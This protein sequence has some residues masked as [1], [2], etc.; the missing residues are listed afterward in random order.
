MH[1]DLPRRY[2]GDIAAFDRSQDRDRFRHDGCYVLHGVVAQNLL[3]PDRR[4]GIAGKAG[5]IFGPKR[6]AFLAGRELQSFIGCEIALPFLVVTFEAGLAIDGL[7]GADET[8]A[9]VSEHGPVVRVP[10]PQHRA[11]D[12]A[13][14]SADRGARPDPARRRIADPR[15]AVVLVNVFDFYS[16]DLVRQVVVL[17]TGNRVRQRVEAK[18]LQSRQEA[19]ELL[20]AKSAE[21]HLGGLPRAGA[22]HESEN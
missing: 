12:L 19:R 17:R 8:Q 14:D 13:R 5:S 3:Q 7:S 2:T 6:R 16:A 4:P 1:A 9:R 15:L 20:A 21:Q 11:R 18:L 10:A 22:G